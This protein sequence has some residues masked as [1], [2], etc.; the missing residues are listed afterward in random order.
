M[1][2]I[3]IRIGWELLGSRGGCTLSQRETREPESLLGGNT[4]AAASLNIFYLHSSMQVELILL[5]FV[6]CV[7]TQRH[8][9]NTSLSMEICLA[10]KTHT[11]MK[12]WIFHPNGYLFYRSSS[13]QKHIK[14]ESIMRKYHEKLDGISSKQAKET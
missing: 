2:P 13:L 5:S 14:I 8:S 3:Q 10:N 12:F 4:A 11:P 9:E 6:V 7:T 1:I